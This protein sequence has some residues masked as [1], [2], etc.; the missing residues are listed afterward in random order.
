MSAPASFVVE[1]DEAELAVR[2]MEIAIGLDRAGDNRS[3]REILRQSERSWPS[4]LPFP[5]RR[6]ARLAIAYMAECAAKGQ[7][8]S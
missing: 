1:I 5:F 2:L 8:P 6:M 7:Q 3:P 4:D